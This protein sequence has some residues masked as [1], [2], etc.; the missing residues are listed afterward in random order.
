MLQI[1][2]NTNI[3]PLR[4]TETHPSNLSVQLLCHSLV[5]L[6]SLNTQTHTDTHSP[7]VLPAE[8]QARRKN[9]IWSSGRPLQWKETP[10]LGCCF[11]SRAGQAAVDRVHS[12]WLFDTED[13]L[14]E[15]SRGLYH[16]TRS[17][18]Q[19]LIHSRTIVVFNLICQPRIVLKGW[20]WHQVTKHKH[21]QVRI[22]YIYHKNN[23]YFNL[24]II[25]S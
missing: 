2:K 15:L 17:T 6:N 25:F 9:L 4:N 24:F 19:D 21:R 10:Y 1:W 7:G 3:F 14:P 20:S 5:H 16:D 22:S 11:Y 8:G 13:L 23:Y 18:H 12:H